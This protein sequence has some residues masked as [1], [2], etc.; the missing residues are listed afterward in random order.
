MMYVM[1]YRGVWDERRTAA[2]EAGIEEGVSL[3]ACFIT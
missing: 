1:V 3:S 2:I